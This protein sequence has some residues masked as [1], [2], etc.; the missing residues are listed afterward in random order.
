MALYTTHR[1]TPLQHPLDTPQVP[2]GPPRTILSNT[3]QT[4]LATLQTE[5]AAAPL[6]SGVH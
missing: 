6:N 4:P 3:S 1:Q 5:Q 2:H